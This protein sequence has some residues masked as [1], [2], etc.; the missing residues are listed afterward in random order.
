MDGR[1]HPSQRI[2]VVLAVAVRLYRDG[3]ATLL[4]ADDRVIVQAAVATS[5]EALAACLERPDVAL[6]DVTLDDATDLKIGRAHV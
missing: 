1:A 2:T 4:G 3:L 5:E 6:I